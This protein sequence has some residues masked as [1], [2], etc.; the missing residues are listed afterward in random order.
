MLLPLEA[1]EPALEGT[2]DATLLR[3]VLTTPRAERETETRYREG[4]VL[5]NEIA[6]WKLRL[7]VKDQDALRPARWS[8]LAPVP[9]ARAPCC[10]RACR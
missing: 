7:Q 3:D 2:G 4:R 9:P 6:T 10:P 1:P 5:A 8:D